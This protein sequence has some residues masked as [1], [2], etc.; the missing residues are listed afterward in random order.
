MPRRVQMKSP[1]WARPAPVLDGGELQVSFAAPDDRKILGTTVSIESLNL[2]VNEPGGIPDYTENHGFVPVL[3]GNRNFWRDFVRYVTVTE[4]ARP[5]ALTL[6]NRGTLA[7]KDVRVEFIVDDPDKDLSFVT[8]ADMPKRPSR[9]F[10]IYSANVP[11]AMA[12]AMKGPAFETERINGTWHLAFNL[13]TLQPARTVFPAIRFFTGSKHSK[14]I[15]LTGRVLA[16]NLPSPAECKLTVQFTSTS[17][18]MNLDEME[19]TFAHVLGADE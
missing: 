4:L 16:E 18:T 10:P 12:A 7:A 8:E 2:I 13:G 14:S 6:T 5:V 17:R 15:V 19:L 1:A 11:Q 9:D 3:V